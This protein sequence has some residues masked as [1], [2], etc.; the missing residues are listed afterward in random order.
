MENIEIIQAMPASLWLILVIL[1]VWDMIWKLIGLW[2]SARNNQFVWF[3]CIAIINTVGILP[4]IY[5]LTHKNKNH[6]K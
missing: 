3:I 4:I 5:I 2:K 1:T 6:N